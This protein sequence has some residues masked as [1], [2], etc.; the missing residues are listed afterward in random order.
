MINNWMMMHFLESDRKAFNFTLQLHSGQNSCQIPETVKTAKQFTNG[1][2]R[3]PNRS[4]G[5][6]R[7]TVPLDKTVEQ[8]KQQQWPKLVD[9]GQGNNIFLQGARKP[10]LGKCFATACV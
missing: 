3:A 1:T 9:F 8:P 10:C 6:T 7:V 4:I 5:Q 2:A